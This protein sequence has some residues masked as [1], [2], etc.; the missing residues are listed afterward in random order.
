MRGLQGQPWSWAAEPAEEQSDPGAGSEADHRGRILEESE[1]LLH[2][3]GDGAH[4][5]LQRIPRRREMGQAFS[6]AGSLKGEVWQMSSNV[7][8]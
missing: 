5:G 6:A 2:E 4:P 8:Q 3:G 7:K 1:E